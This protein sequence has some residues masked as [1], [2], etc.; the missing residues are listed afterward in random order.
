MRKRLI[1]K[2]LKKKRGF[3]PPFFFVPYLVFD[4][5]N[6]SVFDVVVFWAIMGVLVAIDIE[7]KGEVKGFTHL[8]NIEKGEGGNVWTKGR[9]VFSPLFG[10]V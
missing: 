7:T 8:L 4:F 1:Y 5:F 6:I 9:G 2:R 10:G 3:P